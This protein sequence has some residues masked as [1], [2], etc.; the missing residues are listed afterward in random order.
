MTRLFLI[1]SFSPQ[2]AWRERNF[3]FVLIVKSL[4]RLRWW[5]AFMAHRSSQQ[6]GDCEWNKWNGKLR[7]YCHQDRKLFRLGV[8]MFCFFFSFDFSWKMLSS[9]S[10]SGKEKFIKKRNSSA[11]HAQK[12]AERCQ[13]LS[14]D[15]AVAT[16]RAE[17]RFRLQW[18]MSRGCLDS[19]PI[20]NGEE[21]VK[22]NILGAETIHFLLASHR[23][24]PSRAALCEIMKNVPKFFTSRC[25]SVWASNDDVCFTQQRMLHVADLLIGYLIILNGLGRIFA[26]LH[27]LEAITRTFIIYSS[28]RLIAIVARTFIDFCAKNLRKSRGGWKQ[29]S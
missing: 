26:S 16:R 21:E 6:L 18:V 9:P 15:I 4:R 25:L 22:K 27:R 3:K 23:L 20:P 17:Q 2:I 14:C 24:S 11:V 7:N 13:V 29:T 8:E 19:R 1:F 12:A 10:K 5:T 28:T